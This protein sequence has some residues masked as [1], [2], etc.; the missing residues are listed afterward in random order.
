MP[1]AAT[2]AKPAAGAAPKKTGKKT[3]AK[4]TGAAGSCGEGTCG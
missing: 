1:A 3:D 2:S 4:K